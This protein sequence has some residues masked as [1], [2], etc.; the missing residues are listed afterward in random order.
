MKKGI[1][2]LFLLL[3]SNA[4]YGQGHVICFFNYVNIN[5]DTVLEIQWFK[6]GDMRGMYLPRNIR[7]VGMWEAHKVVK[8]VK[9]PVISRGKWQMPLETRET[10][11]MFLYT[12]TGDYM[13]SVDAYWP[14]NDKCHPK[15]AAPDFIP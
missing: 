12:S 6:E 11:R 10:P 5:S 1:A 4:S 2:V 9:G 3:L 8:G 13:D 14:K 15:I 7:A